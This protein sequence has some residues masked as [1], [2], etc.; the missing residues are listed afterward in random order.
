M[1]ACILVPVLFF[2]PLPGYELR[3]YA[4]EEQRPVCDRGQ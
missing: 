3:L 1:N 4:G 2:I